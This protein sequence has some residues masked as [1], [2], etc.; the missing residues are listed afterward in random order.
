MNKKILAAAAA[1]AA[2]AV[3][4]AISWPDASRD[5]GKCADAVAAVKGFKVSGGAAAPL[6]VPF[7]TGAAGEEARLSDF[8]GQGLVVNF[9]ATWCPP[10]IEEMPSVLRLKRAAPDGVAVLA[11]NEDREGAAVAAAFLEKNGWRELGLTVDRKGALLRALKIVGLPTTVLITPDGREAA[12]LTGTTE[13]DG[14]QAR[15]IIDA[16]IAPGGKG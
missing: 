15:R 3:I 14:E 1:L 6:D 11:V 12:R 13:W 9:W 7:F 5:G 10:C 4:V 8:V 2:A 16:C